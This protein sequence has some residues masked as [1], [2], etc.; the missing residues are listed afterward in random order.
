MKH[1]DFDL[2]LG[3]VL[4]REQ[5]E[6]RIAL[7]A[8]GGRYSWYDWKE[9]TWN[10]VGGGPTIQANLGTGI[11][12]MYVL[13]VGIEEG[14]GVVLCCME[15]VTGKFF[16][17]N[18]TFVIP[19][20]LSR[21]I[22]FL[23]DTKELTDV[24]EGELFLLSKLELENIQ[25]FSSIVLRILNGE[26]M[27]HFSAFRLILDW[28]Q[29]FSDYERK[30]DLLPYSV[31][32]FVW[33]EQV[34]KFLG[35]KIGEWFLDYYRLKNSDES[36]IEVVNKEFFGD[37]EIHIYNFF[38]NDGYAIGVL[39]YEDDETS[40]KAIKMVY[41][42]LADV[43]SDHKL[44]DYILKYRGLYDLTYKDIGY[45]DI[46]VALGTPKSILYEV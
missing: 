40:P 18:W 14:D 2:L 34:D 7:E 46:M 39:D 26:Y 13:D 24:G 12:D 19:G 5:Q 28:S 27:D 11:A 22:D 36:E 25:E 10:C 30:N 8:F 16:E 41:P 23:P 45:G 43:L 29:E 17:F 4:V 31:G 21:I 37:K 15:G 42:K 9:Q 32:E 20:T 6:L 3:E 1:S 35:N 38:C 44:C 33:Y